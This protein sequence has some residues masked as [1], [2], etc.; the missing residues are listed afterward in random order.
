MVSGADTSYATDLTLLKNSATDAALVTNG[1]TDLTARVT[2]RGP[3]GIGQGDADRY[4]STPDTED[5][6]ALNLG[7]PT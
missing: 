1:N 6:T 5:F 3:A 4:T 7:V 2:V